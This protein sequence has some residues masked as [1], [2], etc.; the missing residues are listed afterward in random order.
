M[1]KDIEEAVKWWQKAAEQ[2]YAEAQY[3]MGI[4]YYSGTGITRD[5][6]EAV[7]WYRKAAEQGYVLAEE[8]LSRLNSQMS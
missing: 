8:A 7:K 4:C 6:T 3:N 5:Y 2:G 1:K